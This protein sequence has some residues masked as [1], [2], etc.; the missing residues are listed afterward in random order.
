MFQTL[1]Y[2]KIEQAQSYNLIDPSTGNVTVLS[3][4][5]IF[6]LNSYKEIVVTHSVDEIIQTAKVVLPKRILGNTF[7]TFSNEL[8][9]L[10]LDGNPIDFSDLGNSVNKIDQLTYNNVNQFVTNIDAVDITGLAFP[11]TDP[12]IIKP[13]LFLR[14]D[15]ITIYLGYLLD[16]AIQNNNSRRVYQY[17]RGYISSV[18]AE[19][20]ITL[21]VEDMM[22][23]LKQLRIPNKYIPS[24]PNLNA[25]NINY[26][27]PISY[28]GLDSSV[29]Q[30]SKNNYSVYKIPNGPENP[31][32]YSIN[33]LPGVLSDSLNNTLNDNQLTAKGCY[34]LSWKN[35]TTAKGNLV[36]P[37]IVLGNQFVRSAGDVKIQN[38]ASVFNLLET[39]KKDF[40]LNVY[41]LQQSPA[42]Q[43]GFINDLPAHNLWGNISQ[44]GYPGN[45]LNLGFGPYVPVSVY[46]PVNYTFTLNGPNCNVISSNLIWKRQ[47]DFLVGAIIKSFS[48]HNSTIDEQPVQTSYGLNTKKGL[49]TNLVVGDLGGSMKT[50]YY[51]KNIVPV[52]LK[53]DNGNIV[54]DSSGKDLYAISGYDQAR[55][56][57]NQIP[58]G[59]DLYNMAVYGYQELNKIHY[60]GFYGSITTFGI[61]PVNIG[62]IVSLVDPLYPQRNGSYIIKKVVI[63]S[64]IS[65]LQQELFLHY[66]VNPNPDNSGNYN[67]LSTSANTNVYYNNKTYTL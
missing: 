36:K 37:A 39:F 6:Y 61:P 45:Y 52:V 62:D 40:N 33:T 19:G 5:K 30:N 43:M 55:G 17:F 3:R 28:S 1:N 46:Q 7:S 67:I 18:S 49:S 31:T 34:P 35:V 41:F 54:K 59:T 2:I 24:D 50:Y 11:I 63:K 22:W 57:N 64:N 48:I 29:V 65:G 9:G 4:N 42:Y 60:T 66:Q 21:E 47:E 26:N 20:D 53:D 44:G 15:M 13:P 25:T 8:R 16:P 56:A 51:A 12:S 10:N 23:Y 58:A 38:N 32:G 27:G 14:G